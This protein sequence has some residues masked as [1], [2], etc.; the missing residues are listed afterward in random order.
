M[1]NVT[2]KQVGTTFVLELTEAEAQYVEAALQQ[3]NP[4]NMDGEDPVWDALSDAMREAGVE[5][6]SC[7]FVHGF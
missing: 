6:D 1:A 4:A 5:S 2:T 7:A 3:G